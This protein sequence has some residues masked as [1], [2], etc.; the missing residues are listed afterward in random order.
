[1]NTG[2]APDPT[3][4]NTLISNEH[5]ACFFEEYGVMGSVRDRAGSGTYRAGLGTAK[6]VESYAKSAFAG[7]HVLVYIIMRA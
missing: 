7:V 4:S 5:T 3:T 1:M 2:R 6:H